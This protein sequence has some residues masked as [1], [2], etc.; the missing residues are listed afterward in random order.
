MK[1]KIIECEN[2]KKIHVFD[3]I[4]DFHYKNNTFTFI[5]NSKFRIGWADRE[6]T[7]SCEY[8]YSSYSMEEYARVNPIIHCK[9]DECA[10]VLIATLENKTWL[11]TMVNLSTQTEPH[12]V[13]TH[14]GM[15]VLYY[16]NLE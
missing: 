9:S 14:K 4:V 15:T 5:K 13:H 10:Q 8:V 12:F 3:D 2:N 7:K 11:K 6:D 16:A 1:Y